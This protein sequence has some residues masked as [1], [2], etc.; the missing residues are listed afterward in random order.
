MANRVYFFS[1]IPMKQS[2]FPFFLLRNTESYILQDFQKE[3][4]H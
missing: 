1:L 2:N 3:I 4:I